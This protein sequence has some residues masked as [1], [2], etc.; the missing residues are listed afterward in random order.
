MGLPQID[1]DSKAVA[2]GGYPFVP[3]GVLRGIEDIGEA[4]TASK[5]NIESAL[6]F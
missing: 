1:N 2:D 5:E 4:N 3:E 6:K